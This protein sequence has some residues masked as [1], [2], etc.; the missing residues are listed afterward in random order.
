MKSSIKKTI[1]FTLALAACSN[2][3][4]ASPGVSLSTREVITAF[5]KSVSPEE[6]TVSIDKTYLKSGQKLKVSHTEGLTLKYYVSEPLT[7]DVK[8][9]IEMTEEE[10]T[11]TDDYYEKFITV[12]AYNTSAPEPVAVDKVFFSKLPVIY[13]DTNDGQVPAFKEDKKKGTFH[14]QNNE[15]TDKALYS[16]KMTM[17]GRGNSTW[18]W[19]KKPYKIKLDKKADFYGFG[20]SKKWV[21]LA[22]YLDES[23]LR[24]TTASGLSEKLGL[25]TMQTTW[26]DLIVNNEYVGNYQL[27]EQVGIEKSRVSIFDWEKEC[28]DA[29]TAVFTALKNTNDWTDDDADELQTLMVEDMSWITTD[30]VVYNDQVINVSEYYEYNKDIT[31][32]YLFES[33]EEFDEVSKFMTDNGLKVMMKSPEFLYTNDEMMQYA[34]NLWQE[35]EDAYRAEDGYSPTTGKHYTEIADL[36]SM[37]SY[38]LL[39][40]IMGNDDARY[41]SRYVYKAHDSLLKFGPPWDFDTGL[42][43]SLV[44]SDGNLNPSL[45]LNP[46]GWKVSNYDIGQNFYREFLDDPLFIVKATEKYWQVRPYLEEIIKEGGLLDQNSE[47]LRESGLVDEQR[48]VRSEGSQNWAEYA[49]GYEQDT[50]FFKQYMRERVAW[51]DT[52]FETDDTLLKTRE[53][54][55]S[56][57]PYKRS[58]DITINVVKGEADTSV[59]APADSAV[60]NGKSVTASISVKNKK[61]KK[62][63]VYINGIYYKTFNVC[64][65]KLTFVIPADKFYGNDSE[66]NV[67][68]VIG[69]NYQNGT[70]GRNFTTVTQYDVLPLKEGFYHVD[71]IPTQEGKLFAGFY[72]DSSCRMP[73]YGNDTAYSKFIDAERYMNPSIIS[74]T[75]SLNGKKANIT[76]AALIDSTCYRDLGF[77]IDTNGKK[78]TVRIYNVTRYGKD[79]LALYTLMNVKKEDIRNTKITA[80]YTT[81]DGRY[82]EGK[83]ITCSL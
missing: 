39:M 46:T 73:Y 75:Y 80:F 76:F 82:V 49:R 31:G 45:E 66:K 32:G 13:I 35:F 43:S 21:L 5:A 22:N 11:L 23:L 34:E 77:I 68:S 51:L 25:T 38:W 52:Q 63:Q 44:T 48:W 28:E 61:T 27:C 4:L 26:V 15:E 17:Q 50:A 9:Q 72:V 60:Q 71:T 1:S 55:N 74:R 33:S 6:E 19:D 3:L 54:I 78:K 12:E 36:D 10:L 7:P 47:Y 79:Y 62:L 37:V 57:S 29:A 40:E 18:Q 53:N 67:I 69:K 14:L 64:S 56:A 30:K 16:G 81:L 65:N 24:N 83:T 70:T 41:K 59:H 20:S 42:G 58:N 2:F 8:T